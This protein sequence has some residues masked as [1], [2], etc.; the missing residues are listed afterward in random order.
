M[1][2][3]LGLWAIPLILTLA[4]LAWAFL[5]PMPRPAGAFDIGGLLSA[6]FR[7]FVVIVA[8]LIAWL[9]WAIVR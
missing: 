8:S 9:G 6:G 7:T 5:M 1:T 4:L 3:T 2:I